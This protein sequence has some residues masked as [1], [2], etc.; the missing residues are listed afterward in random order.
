M[1]V[2]ADISLWWLIPLFLL[3]L[4]IAYFFYKKDSL[5][6]EISSRLRYLLIGLRGLTIFLLL[7]LLIGL[8]LETR[9]TRKEKPVL[10]LLKDN[11]SSI[12]NYKDSLFVL[13]KINKLETQV[14]IQLKDEYQLEVVNFDS[15]S[16]DEFNLKGKATD[17]NRSFDEIFNEYYNRNL[18]GICLISDGNYNE[19]ANPMLTVNK[20]TT[21]PIYTVIV[22]DTI[23]KKDIVLNSVLT[24]KIAFLNNEFPLEVNVNANQLKGKNAT[25]QVYSEGKLIE[26]RLISIESNSAFYTEQF[27]LNANKIGFVNYTVNVVCDANEYSKENNSS[28]VYIEIIDSRNKVLMLANGPHPDFA[29]IRS[30]ISLDEKTEITSALIDNWDGNLNGVELLI[31]SAGRNSKWQ[32]IID[33][34]RVKKIP[35]LLLLQ[36][37]FDAKIIDKLGL[38]LKAP[39]SGKTDEVQ[40][41][42]NNDFSLF[43][44]STEMQ[45]LLKTAPPIQV[46]FGEVKF[47]G[48]VLVKQRLGG[49]QKKDPIIGF[50]NSNGQKFGFLLGEGLWRWKI[51]EYAHNKNNKEFNELI[52]KSVQFLTVKNNKDRLRIQLPEEFVESSEVK[53]RAEFYNKSLE[54]IITPEIDFNLTRDE[55]LS[56]LTFAKLSKNYELNLGNLTK[57]VY[58]WEAITEFEGV[59]YKKEGSFVVSETNKENFDTKANNQLLKEL[60]NSTGG[61]SA[62]LDNGKIIIDALL[63][64]EN[65][66]TLNYTESNFKD[67]IEW[68]WILILLIVSL[69]LEWFFRRYSGSY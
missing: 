24:N 57:G 45:E 22:G 8:L 67:L 62:P 34:V 18:A 36:N 56:K 33:E 42:I 51:N 6:K 61:V 9:E 69:S 12:K 53:I 10:V 40:S 27:L 7:I 60:S 16:V 46:P 13:D 59:K 54:P 48:D 21:T 30:A 25:I 1:K 66:V 49:V 2:Y 29:A 15:K 28:S 58:H 19:G 64:N 4:F 32:K 14:N 43:E 3:T 50:G 37:G 68:Y 65:A 5:T 17:I 63:K 44:I 39:S 35:T 38:N 31:L 11:S 41:Y 52:Q 26:S 55:D 47:T 23:E 20:M